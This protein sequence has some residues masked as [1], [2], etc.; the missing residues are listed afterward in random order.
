MD[1]SINYHIYII[2]NNASFMPISLIFPSNI[3]SKL[4]LQKTESTNN[5]ISWK[6]EPPTTP[7]IQYRIQKPLIPANI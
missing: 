3:L 2:V 6:K 7:I 5:I 1:N 4:Q